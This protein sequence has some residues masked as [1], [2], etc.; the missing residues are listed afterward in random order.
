MVS[1]LA[2]VKSRVYDNYYILLL[3]FSYTKC[4]KQ[5]SALMCL[6]AGFWA[7]PL[8]Q[9]V[10][11]DKCMVMIIVIRSMNIH[12]LLL[13]YNYVIYCQGLH[14]EVGTFLGICVVYNYIIHPCVYIVSPQTSF[15]V[16]L[17]RHVLEHNYR[18]IISQLYTTPG[19]LTTCSYCS[20]LPGDQLHIWIVN[21]F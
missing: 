4:F 12:A 10:I 19:V 6:F 15:T 8:P 20:V 17:Y 2:S 16:Y 1:L 3:C 13:F 14:A 5:N 7:E 11:S 9:N 21:T 18:M